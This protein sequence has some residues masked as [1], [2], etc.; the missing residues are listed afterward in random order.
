MLCR[1][2]R[3]G[4]PVTACTAAP[5]RPGG[6]SRGVQGSRGSR[7]PGGAGSPRGKRGTGAVEGPE[8]RKV[9]QGQGPPQTGISPL[10]VP[11]APSI[12]PIHLKRLSDSGKAEMPLSPDICGDSSSGR[13]WTTPHPVQPQVP[14][15]PPTPVLVPGYANPNWAAGPHSPS[16]PS[17]PAAACGE[18][19]R[20]RPAHRGS[21]R[22]EPQPRSRPRSPL[23]HRSSGRRGPG[24]GRFAGG[25]AGH[26]GG[27]GVL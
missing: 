23:P 4:T 2:T 16:A 13:S 1:G 9:G 10:T 21:P 7:S 25:C 14:L 6:G 3:W 20:Y 19:A 22:P 12:V 8:G 17:V 26:G 5:R 27:V 15:G 18:S 11:A 24:L